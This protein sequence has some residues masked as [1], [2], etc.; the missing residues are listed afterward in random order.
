MLYVG[1][2]R[3]E[4]VKDLIVGMIERYRMRMFFFCV[5]GGGRENVKDLIVGMIE[6]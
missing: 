4:R 3:R 6:I 5:G 2:G 1:R